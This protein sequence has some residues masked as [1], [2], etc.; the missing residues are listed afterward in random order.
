MV[1][2]NK[3]QSIH[4]VLSNIDRR[5]VNNN[6]DRHKPYGGISMVVTGDFKQLGKGSRIF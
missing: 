4:E 6:S 3:N 5:D 2:A 1:G